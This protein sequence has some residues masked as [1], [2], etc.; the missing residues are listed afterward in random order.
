[1]A[2]KIK[3][4]DFYMSLPYEKTIKKL[5]EDDGGGYMAAVPLLGE[6]TVNAWGKTEAEALSELN[7]VMR[8]SFERWIKDGEEIPEPK[9]DEKIYSG[10]F[11][12]R[13]SPYLHR[14]VSMFA[15]EQ[16]VSLNQLICNAVSMYI[17]GAGRFQNSLFNSEDSSLKTNEPPLEFTDSNAIEP[18]P[19]NDYRKIDTAFNDKDYQE[20]KQ[21]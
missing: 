20:A 18:I 7:D 12:L 5:K 21:G 4:A 11:A 17:G 14:L 9:D 1:M 19:L 3:N 15:D 8:E 13:M 2:K 6:M 16:G 10:K